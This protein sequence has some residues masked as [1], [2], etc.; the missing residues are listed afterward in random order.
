MTAGFACKQ[1]NK[2]R[3]AVWQVGF[4]IALRRKNLDNFY[5]EN[6][7]YIYYTTSLI[8]PY[9]YHYYYYYNY[10]YYCYCFFYYCYTALAYS[11]A[12]R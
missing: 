2:P 6:T 8:T 10:H 11:L 1:A 5:T 7:L 12:D 4:S 3:Q 9:Y